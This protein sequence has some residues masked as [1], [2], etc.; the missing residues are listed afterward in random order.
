MMGN[1]S[2]GVSLPPEAGITLIAM[3]GNI[4]IYNVTLPWG[5]HATRDGGLNDTGRLPEKDRETG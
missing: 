5:S 2:R 1:L 4:A 3:T